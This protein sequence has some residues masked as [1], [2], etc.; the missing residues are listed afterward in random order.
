[1]FYLR[2]P[3]VTLVGS[4]PEI[5]VRVVDGKV[6]VRPLAGTRRR[7]QTEE[8]DRRLAEE[9]LA[10]P[11]ERAEHVMLVDLGRNDVGRVARYGSVELT[12][13]MTIER[14]SHV[15]HITP[16]S[17]G[18]LA[19]GKDAF[20]ALR[21]CLPAGTVSGAPKVRAME[22]IDELEP[23]RRGPY[24]G[25]VGYVDFS[26][27]MDTCIAL[28]TIVIPEAKVRQKR[29][30]PSRRRH[31]RRQPA[32]NPPLYQIINKIGRRAGRG[33]PDGAENHRDR[34]AGRV[35]AG[36]SIVHEA[37]LPD[38]FELLCGTGPV[39]GEALARHP[40]VD[41]VSFTGS[42][43]SGT[44]VAELAAATVKRVSLELGGKSANVVLPDA[45]LGTAVER[46]MARAFSNSGQGCIA[47]TGLL[48]PRGATTR[49][50]TWPWR[51]PARYPVATRA[52]RPPAGSAG[53]RRQRD[54]VLGHIEG[55][56]V[57][58]APAG[59]RLRGAAA[60][61]HDRALLRPT[62]F[63][64]VTPGMAH[65]P[66][67]DLRP[68]AVDPLLRARTRPSRSRTARSFGLPARSSADLDHAWRWP[69]DA[70]RAARGQRLGAGLP[71]ALRRL[72]PLR[73]TAASWP[74]G[75]EEYLEVKLLCSSRACP[76][77]RGRRERPVAG[78][79]A[80]RRRKPPITPCWATS[81]TPRGARR[82]PRSR[83]KAAGRALAR[84]AAAAVRAGWPDCPANTSGRITPGL[85]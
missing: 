65:R 32:R 23:H 29:L 17:T 62:V 30:R 46:G 54:R 45:D 57:D 44:R 58:G 7:G 67:G 19:D 66:G 38:L 8:E 40:G 50:S 33:L 71:G 81:A 16:T 70:G 42:T 60:G 74:G 77:C 78:C 85:S 56:V 3:S 37:G 83:P 15:M 39:V 14:Y 47:L 43:R 75:L 73:A 53:V 51:R 69:A 28:R 24:A 20:D 41:L 2:T 84:A 27:N 64:E 13:V 82:R 6:T 9:L 59:D 31:R 22:I 55:G 26:G 68:G 79:I 49:W 80:R 36:P 11:K 4:S 1:M 35:R 61:L 10:D 34:A 12:D 76:A 48:A 72:R 52:M 25:A 5:M 21:A 63:G 18:M